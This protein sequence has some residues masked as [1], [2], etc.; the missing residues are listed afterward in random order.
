MEDFGL[1]LVSR[2]KFIIFERFK[3][4]SYIF[5]Q[6]SEGEVAEEQNDDRRQEVQ[7]GGLLF[8]RRDQ[9]GDDVHAGHHRTAQVVAEHDGVRVLH[10]QFGRGTVD[11]VLVEAVADVQQDDADD[12]EREESQWPR[13]GVEQGHPAG[14]RHDEDIGED[15]AGDQLVQVDAAE[16]EREEE[17]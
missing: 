15:R 13:A 3:C 6:L 16:R 2:S 7:E 4:N 11:R 14:E 1:V 12:R 17:R 10:R 9:Q 5:H 8:V